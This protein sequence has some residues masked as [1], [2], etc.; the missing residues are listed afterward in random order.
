METNLLYKKLIYLISL[1]SVCWM[2]SCSEKEEQVP[3]EVKL[4]R[5]EVEIN[6]L[7]FSSNGDEP[8]IEVASNVYWEISKGENAEWLKVSP[9]G[10][11]GITKVTIA[12]L[13]NEGES[14]SAELTL[15]TLDGV[16]TTI[17][18]NQ[19]GGD[20]VVNF[21]SCDFGGEPG[22]EMVPVM[23]YEAWDATGVGVLAAN[24]SGVH[25]F[26]D[27]Q[28]PSNSYE[29][30]SGGNNILF[31]SENSVFH[32]GPLSTKSN[33]SFALSFGILGEKEGLVL[34]ASN[35][36]ENWIE[37]PYEQLESSG[38][39]MAEAK[40]HL[41][42]QTSYMYFRL[43][44][45]SANIYRIDDIKILEGRGNEGTLIDFDAMVDDDKPAGFVYFEDRFDWITEDFGGGDYVGGSASGIYP[46][47]GPRWDKLPADCKP[48]W[49]A[50][51]WSVSSGYVTY[52]ALGY[53]Q[54][55]STSA[56]GDMITPRLSS[57]IPSYTNIPRRSGIGIGKAV[58]VLVSFDIS[59][60]M[61]QTG[62]QDADDIVME[63]LDAGTLSNKIDKEMKIE[64]E[65]WNNWK[66]ITIPVMG[67]TSDTRI[68]IKYG[69]ASP[70]AR[71]RFFFDHLKVEKASKE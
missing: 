66:R 39:S 49:N 48:I 64:V 30:A 68:R 20:E 2:V 23:A 11:T 4:N 3:S 9:M 37:I 58:N 43:S 7:G 62:N 57:Y 40:F 6:K 52:M 70:G 55:G 21:F 29:S 51:G 31:N 18:I 36:D 71:N 13:K 46:A 56:G 63:V 50:S 16:R 69:V 65:S 27:N 47:T 45:S 44:G 34:E 67:A 25:A 8:G 32:F 12:A 19:S 41:L 22:V 60:Y 14:R 59:V 42:N 53:V 35:D 1:L 38:W 28:S 5:T 15:E 33:T 24:F 10:G 17:R 61:G 26:V 54:L